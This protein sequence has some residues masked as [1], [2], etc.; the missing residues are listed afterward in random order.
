MFGD[1]VSVGVRVSLP[2][3]ASQRQEP[4]IRARAL[5]ANRVAVEREA[6][7]RA[8]LAALEGDLA[9]HTMHR[10]QWLR[11]RDQLLPVARAQADLE[12]AGYGAGTAG[13]GD[14]L[15]AFSALADAQLDA[16]EREARFAR[17]V[18]RIN[19]TYG[20]DAP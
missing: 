17:D 14:V 11:A 4:V 1:M 19:L 12:T 9:E 15:E 3:F 2:L 16:L 6:A 10:E 18:I 8:M 5:D 7:R 20:S 13:L